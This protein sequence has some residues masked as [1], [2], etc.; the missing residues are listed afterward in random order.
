MA[1][2][3]KLDH[4]VGRSFDQRIRTLRLRCR[5]RGREHLGR[6]PHAGRGIFGLARFARRIAP[7]CCKPRRD[8]HGHRRGLRAELEV[9]GVLGADP[10]GAGRASAASSSISWTSRLASPL[11]LACRGFVHASRYP[12]LRRALSRVPLADAGATTISASMS[13]TAGPRAIRAGS[14]SC[15]CIRTAA[16]RRSPSA[17]LRETSNRLANALRAHGI[18]RGDRVAILLPQAPE[19]AAAHIAIYKLGAVALPLADPVRR[20]CAQLPAAEFRR[21]GADHQR[22][23]RSPSSPTSAHESPVVLVLSIDGAGRRRARICTTLLARASRRL[24]AGRHDARR[25]RR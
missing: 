21:E 7:T 19:V 5:R 9:Q 22:A 16:A 15:T 11:A 24:H 23:G 13:A 12:R 20:R 8:P 4:N 6:L 18:A 3:D 25:S 2:R 1:A 10:G 14:R 17:A